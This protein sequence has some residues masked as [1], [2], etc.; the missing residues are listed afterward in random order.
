MIPCS[1]PT[2]AFV[3]LPCDLRTPT[4]RMPGRHSWNTMERLAVCATTMKNAKF[5]QLN[6]LEPPNSHLS[7]SQTTL[8]KDDNSRMCIHIYIYICIYI[9]IHIHVCMYV[10]MYLHT[11]ISC[12]CV[13]IY[14]CICIYTFI[15]YTLFIS[16]FIYVLIY[17]CICR[18]KQ[19]VLHVAN[20]I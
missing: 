7:T 11:Y 15:H 4:S 18:E 3:V 14:V 20:K 2:D 19:R 17:L 10:C 16:L 9:Y 6:M 1:R 8:R 5:H 12:I 13:H